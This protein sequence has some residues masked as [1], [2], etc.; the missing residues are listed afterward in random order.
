MYESKKQEQE[1]VCLS[2]KRKTE[3]YKERETTGDRER[4]RAEHKRN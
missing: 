2:K 1:D 4:E 3:R